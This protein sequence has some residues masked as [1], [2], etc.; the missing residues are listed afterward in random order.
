MPT[1]AKSAKSVVSIIQE[2]EIARPLDDIG[3]FEIDLV[4]NRIIWTNEC[5]VCKSGYTIDQ[6]KHMTLFDLTPQASHGCIHEIVSN[7][8]ENKPIVDKELTSIWPMQ[9]FDKKIIWWAITKLVIEYP[10]V[11]VY[12]NHIQTTGDS[13]MSYVFMCTFMRAANGQVGLYNQ[14][15]ELKAWTDDQIKK[16]SDEDKNLHAGLSSLERKLEEALTA[17]KEAAETSRASAAMTE[18]LQKTFQNIETKYGSEI[19]KLVN[20][21]SV[22]DKRID[23]FEKHIQMTTDLAIGSIKMQAENYSKNLSRKIVIPVS[24]I[25]GIVTIIQILVERFVK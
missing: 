13:D 23:A 22:H 12:G 8:I 10:I 16:L 15:S 4:E 7:I 5:G 25:A 2:R 6:I 17:S 18:N 11:L 21:D 19:L 1:R 14:L 24:V 3:V 9:T 20:I